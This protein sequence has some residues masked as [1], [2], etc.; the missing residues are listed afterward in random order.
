M[1]FWVG[2]KEFGTSLSLKVRQNGS[3]A[4]HT[5]SAVKIDPP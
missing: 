4:A 5:Y 1:S 2:L 3:N